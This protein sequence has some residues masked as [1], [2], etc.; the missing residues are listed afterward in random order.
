M[1]AWHSPTAT[2]ALQLLALAVVPVCG[3]DFELEITRIYEVTR[4]LRGLRQFCGCLYTI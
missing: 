1:V 4:R 2:L 3:A